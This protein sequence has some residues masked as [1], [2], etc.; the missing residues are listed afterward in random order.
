MD[1]SINVKKRTSIHSVVR[2][3]E[4][5]SANKE[6]AESFVP[7]FREYMEAEGFNKC[8]TAMSLFFWK[9]MPNRTYISQEKKALPGHRPM[10]DRLPLLCGTASGD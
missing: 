6:A 4:A 5:A 2:H 3:G 9:K 10:K 8:L 7:E 1:D